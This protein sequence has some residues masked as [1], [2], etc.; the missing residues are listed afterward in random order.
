LFHVTKR[1]LVAGLRSIGIGECANFFVHS[2]MRAFGHVEGGAETVCDALLEAAGSQ[3]TVA[4]PTFTW[5]QNIDQEF[6]QFDLRRDPC[7]TGAI[8][9]AFRRRPGALRSGHVCHSVAAIGPLAPALMGDGV[10]AFGPGSSMHQLYELDFQYVFLG[11]GFEVCTA[12]H[13]AE[14]LV[15]VPYRRY[16]HYCGSSV[17]LPDGRIIPSR[18]IEYCRLRPYHNDF[19]LM[20]PVYRKA[21]VLRIGQIGQ[22]RVMCAQTR[23]IVNIAVDLLN[24]DIGALLSG[25][26]RRY[27]E[28]DETAEDCHEK[29]RV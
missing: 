7:E 12:L 17:L 13:I 4:V 15:Q 1:D 25:E 2:S 22:A 20:E 28:S 8:P 29:Q 3:G 24:K 19:G 11:I 18:A 26:S 6:V 10:R 23:D 14:E 16:R 5:K 21:G 27:L 9:E